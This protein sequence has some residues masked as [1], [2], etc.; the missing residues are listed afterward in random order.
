MS[1]IERRAIDQN[2]TA[3]IRVHGYMIEAQEST[4]LRGYARGIATTND[5]V[6][7]KQLSGSGDADACLEASDNRSV[8]S[9]E[10]GYRICT[11]GAPLKSCY[12]PRDEQETSRLRKSIQ[13]DL[14]PAERGS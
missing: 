6:T 1:N 8:R 4:V 9:S 14:W 2:S 3:A 5:D 11:G 10:E 13:R 12:R 7:R